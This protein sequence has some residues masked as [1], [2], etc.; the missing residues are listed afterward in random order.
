[1][2]KT[3]EMSSHLDGVERK[4]ERKKKKME[5]TKCFF[6]RS[7]G[8]RAMQRAAKVEEEEAFLI[9]KMSPNMIE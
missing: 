9:K 3:K 6:V 5:G 4:G 2:A 7:A 1:M 8:V